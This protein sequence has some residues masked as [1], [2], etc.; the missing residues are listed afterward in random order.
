MAPRSYAT[1]AVVLRSIRLGE[2]DRV[3]HLYTAERGRLGA[4]AKGVRKTTS[5]FGGRLEPLSHVEL[6]L[7]QGSGELQTITGVVLRGSHQAAR[8]DYYRLSVGLIGA[9]AM[10]RLFTEQERNERAFVALT[11]FLDVLDSSPHAA[12]RPALD[13]L[14]LA[15]QLKLL[16]LSGYLPH[17]T[18]CAECGAEDATLVGY[19]PRAGGA[20]CRACANQ[21]EALALSSDGVR[22]IE[23]LLASPLADATALAL[24]ERAARDALRVV[25][26][27]Y[28]Y[29]GGFRLR[30]LSA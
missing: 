3:L 23:A 13:P 30:T 5:R 24:T 17:L 28:E 14:G 20:V 7:H 6:Q 21:S 11:R 29:H 2:A 25:T 15:F 22:G 4:V 12:D 16:W 9:E 10:L 19:S 26:A 18:S 27:S 8:D 1:E